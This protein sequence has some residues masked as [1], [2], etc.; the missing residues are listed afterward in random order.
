[1]EYVFTVTDQEAQFIAQGLGEL[2]TKV[3]MGLLIKLQKQATEQDKAESIGMSID[4]N[5]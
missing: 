1:M 4:D 5:K 3:G 2:P